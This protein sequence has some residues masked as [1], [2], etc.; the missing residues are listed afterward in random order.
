MDSFGRPLAK[1]TPDDDA[2]LGAAQSER[3][4]GLERDLSD[5]LVSLLEP[6]VGEER[7]RVN[8]AVR[9]SAA[10][11]EQTEEKWDPNTTVIRSRQLTTDGTPTST[12]GAVAGA[13]AN[14]P[15]AAGPNG[16]P[17]AAPPAPLLAAAGRS[18]E[19]TNYEISRTT[20]HT[21]KPSGDVAR[22]SV[23]VI[24]DD[25]LVVKKDAKGTTTRS[26]RSRKPDELQKIHGL[27]AAAVGID[28][29]R[30]DLLTVENIA[31][32]A[33][34]PEEPVPPT[35]MEQYGLVA[36][37]GAKVI[38]VLLLVGL[39][40]LVV[41]KPIVQGAM[42]GPRAMPVAV[43][44][45]GVAAL[46]RTVQDIEGEIEAQLVAAADQKRLEGV[47]MPVLTKKANAIV[48]NEPEA[49]ARLL[50]SWLAEGER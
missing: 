42:G 28:P 6:V 4:R 39:V 44:A 33:A 9:L 17:P 10:S 32:D 31:F 47:K 45:G 48:Q 3:Q 16:V 11:E 38:G 36:G 26:S 8:V 21:V 34:P 25:E 43:G 14:L 41:I 49:A 23:A 13:R 27:V 15:A 7:V 20:R 30:G 35:L 24:L 46:P 5:R 50:R 37:E 18:S 29:A 1:P 22:L 40:I 2:P 12:V 19:T